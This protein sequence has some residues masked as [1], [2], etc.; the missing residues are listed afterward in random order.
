MAN[1]NETKTTNHRYSLPEFV[2]AGIIAEI[3]G[4]AACTI[5]F[6]FGADGYRLIFGGFVR[7]GSKRCV[8]NDFPPNSA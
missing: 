3:F 8:K 1:A 4:I 6:S 2:V 7:D 5:G